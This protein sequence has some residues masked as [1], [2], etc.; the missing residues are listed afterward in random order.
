MLK[1]RRSRDRLIFN[2]GIP[3]P[4]KEALYIETEPRIQLYMKYSFPVLHVR[5][6]DQ[7]RRWPFSHSTAWHQEAIRH[8]CHMF[9]AFI[10]WSSIHIQ[11]KLDATIHDD[12]IK[13]KSPCYRSQH[14]LACEGLYTI[15]INMQKAKRGKLIFK[16]NSLG[17]WDHMRRQVIKVAFLLN[18]LILI[19]ALITSHMSIKCELKYPSSNLN[20]CT[21]GI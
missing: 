19:P 9:S 8:S 15:L 16:D 7:C 20:G 3:I 2:M 1:I 5:D 12:V 11:S 6:C 4:G 21:I 14:Q 18:G 10:A 17:A 13:W